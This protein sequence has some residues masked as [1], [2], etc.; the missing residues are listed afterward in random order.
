[1]SYFLRPID[2]RPERLAEDKLPLLGCSSIDKAVEQ[3]TASCNLFDT[4]AEAIEASLLVRAELHR[5]SFLRQERQS[6][7][8]HYKTAAEAE[9][10]ISIRNDQIRESLRLNFSKCYEELADI[11][12]EILTIHR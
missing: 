7:H 6:I 10:Q 11:I 9:N 8:E 5:L 2:F 3:L 1:M 12:R 4:E